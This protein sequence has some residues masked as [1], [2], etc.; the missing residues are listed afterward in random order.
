GQIDG[1]LDFDGVDDYVNINYQIS[2]PCSVFFKLYPR[3]LADVGYNQ[4]LYSANNAF[5]FYESTSNKFALWADG[6]HTVTDTLVY[7]NNWYDFGMTYNGTTMQFYIDGKPDNSAS[8]SIVF[9]TSFT[10]G[11]SA[12]GLDSLIDEVR[13]SNVARTAGWIETE[14]NNQFS[15]DSF[16]SVGGEETGDDTYPQFSNYWDD[17]ESLLD[18]GTG[19]FNVTVLNTNGTVI[20]EI[21]GT[22]T[23]ATNVSNLFNVSYVF[24]SGGTYPYKWHSWGNGTNAN[25]NVS[26]ERNYVVNSSVDSCT[27]PGL[28]TNWEIDLSDYCNI[29]TNCNLSTGNITFINSGYVLF[30]AT[31]SANKISWKDGIG[32]VERYNLGSNF[33]GWIG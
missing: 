24:S 8:L 7:N 31:L 9:G 25:Y 1:S 16:Y 22:N 28:A 17:N 33:R 15:P 23:T 20:L 14:Y 30:N 26:V 3:D 2:A 32:V 5:N 21:N 4:F 10:L 11:K 29:T 18:S 13:I 27:C 6:T 12:D 19:H